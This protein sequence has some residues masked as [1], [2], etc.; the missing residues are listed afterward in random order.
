MDD[1]IP[2][3]HKSLIQRKKSLSGSAQFVHSLGSP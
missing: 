1:S 2:T 3:R